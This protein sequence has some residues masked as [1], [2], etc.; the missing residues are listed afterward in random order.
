MATGKT[1]NGKPYAGNPHVR[2][3]E[4]EVASTATP[5]RGSLLYKN[6]QKAMNG[7]SGIAALVA[8]AI[9]AAASLT[10]FA[11][12]RTISAD[13]ALTADETVDGVLTVD[14]GATVDLAGHNLTVKG[15]AGGGTITSGK[16]SLDTSV[17]VPE[18]VSGESIFW[19][20][21]SASDTLT[22]EDGLVKAWA[23]RK[24]SNVAKYLVGSCT[25]PSFDDTTYGI[26]V[27]DFGAAGSK[28]DL[29]F[30]AIGTLRTVFLVTK[31][32][33]MQ[34][35]FWLAAP[36]LGSSVYPFHRGDNGTYAA[37]Y[38]NIARTWNGTMQANMTTEAP[39][40]TS[41]IVAAIETKSNSTANSL[42]NDR[43][44]NGRNGGRQLAELVCFS[45]VLTD[46]ERIAVTEYLQQKWLVPAELRVQVSGS[47]ENST[48]A[49]TGNVKLV[50]EG[51]G[52][53]TASKANQTYTGGTE[54]TGSGTTLVAGTA[55]HP[56]G[57]GGAAQTVTVGEGATVN[58]GTCAN[59]GTCVY[60]YNL[61]GSLV[62]GYEGGRG[63]RRFNFINVISDS[64]SLSIN[65]SLIGGTADNSMGWLQLNGHVFSI[66]TQNEPLMRYIAALDY[67]TIKFTGGYEQFYQNCDLTKARVWF[68]GSSWIHLADYGFNA[69]DFRCDVAQWRVFGNGVNRDAQP[70]IS[71][72]YEAGANR[73][74]LTLLSGATLDISGVS[75]TWSADGRALSAAGSNVNY[76]EPGLVTF[77]SANASYTIDAGAR[78]VAAGD[79]LVAFPSS[80]SPGDTVTFTA[81]ATGAAQTLEERNLALKVKSG[82]GIY[83]RSTEVPYARWH[84]DATTP[85]NSGW[86]FYDAKTGAERTDW[87]DGIT[88]DVEVR[89]SSYAEWTAIQA[90]SVTPLRYVMDGAVT[91]DGFDGTWAIANVSVAEGT[92]LDLN[93]RSVS[94]TGLGG[95]ATV[96]DST[97]D[98][99]HPGELHIVVSGTLSN[100]DTAM[101][102][103]M[104]LVIEGGG[105][106][107]AAKAGQSY[108]GGTEVA[109]GMTLAL[110]T[111]THP[112]GDGNASQTVTLGAGAVFSAGTYA[113]STTCAYS[114]TLG[115]GSSLVF[116]N[117]DRATRRFVDLTLLGDASLTMQ[118]TSG[119]MGLSSR[120]STITL[121]NNTLSM[122]LGSNSFIGHIKTL[123]S[124]TIRFAKS[125]GNG[126]QAQ[127][128][129]TDFR[130]ADV[131]VASQAYI[132]LGNRGMAVCSLVYESAKWRSYGTARV[133]IHGKYAA[134]AFRPAIEMQGG[135]T[136][137]LSAVTG[138]WSASGTD[139]TD[140][141][142]NDI[143][144]AGSVTFASGATIGVDLSGRTDLKELAKS[145]TPYVVTWS[146]QPNATFTLDAE[147][148]ERFKI[149]PDGT[150]IKLVRRSGFTIIVK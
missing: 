13:Y 100:A 40:D 94:L 44:Y 1:L 78:E 35:A 138:T 68:A 38:S 130:T 143:N 119:P 16:Y 49:L 57:N 12:D 84:I 137:D 15:L 132:H 146:S 118:G 59:G 30:D 125:E 67:G 36:N 64:A 72:R 21:A 33:K 112:L 26:P 61:G 108:T 149:K 93:G 122:S 6:L 41:F 32:Q 145:A 103:N 99:E 134:A 129:E 70:K 60:N 9:C 62:C 97:T 85:A 27:V 42:T 56:F 48:V 104:K 96:T 105:T 77:L 25:Y 91:A 4:G 3:D 124:G 147:T 121:N 127:G 92:T 140:R 51:G 65:H 79:K 111:A 95:M 110:G 29:A 19:L 120:Y 131:E 98:A 113:N 126:T 106:F 142:N 58:L 90:Q 52:T 50:V 73:P 66:S 45:R 133:R 76:T 89:F 23:S 20:D 18:I 43:N 123:D 101:T 46:A 28:K 37:T 74:P 150:G 109:A 116:G 55:T 5:R 139:P 8:V 10:S 69:K 24:G 107:T 86:R 75:G 47:V 53:F 39:D 128:A 2:F 102:G 63:T 31:I 71:G 14:S 87:E 82:D 148:A 141:G 83:L 114:F 115:A 144:T 117:A 54:V 34:N 7:M 136:L 17:P 135:S 11:A 80:Y 88:D 81:T 22:I